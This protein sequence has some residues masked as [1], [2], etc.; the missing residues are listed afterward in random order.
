[1]GSYMISNQKFSWRSK[2]MVAM[3]GV[4]LV[5]IIARY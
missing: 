3:V 2:M 5:I 1:M 4:V